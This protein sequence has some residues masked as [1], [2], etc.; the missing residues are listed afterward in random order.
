MHRASATPEATRATSTVCWGVHVNVMTMSCPGCAGVTYQPLAY[1]SRRAGGPRSVP[2]VVA[3]HPAFVLSPSTI[4]NGPVGSCTTT[5]AEVA[6]WWRTVRA[7][8]APDCT[9][10]RRPPPV[11]A[12]A[13]PPGAESS[14]RLS[15]SMPT[16][17][18]KPGA[19]R[20]TW[21][22]APSVIPT[23]AVP[24]PCRWRGPRAW[25]LAA[26]AVTWTGTGCPSIDSRSLRHGDG[27]LGRQ[28]GGDGQPG[29]RP[30]RPRRWADRSGGRSS[31]RAR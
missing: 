18:S 11:G 8:A 1:P 17:R 7:G 13:A 14:T 22:P 26:L 28:R 6:F 21:V 12:S 5:V 9:A 15:T 25:A 2:D 23:A 4:Q 19:V 29:D 3:C 31:S 27:D 24:Q 30:L 20:S 16:L 10:R